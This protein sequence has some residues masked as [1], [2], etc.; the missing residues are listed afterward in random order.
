[1]LLCFDMLI[2]MC[3]GLVKLRVF[4]R[5]SIYLREFLEFGALGSLSIEG[6]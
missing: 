5:F 6:A 1:M 3:W 2:S 4:M